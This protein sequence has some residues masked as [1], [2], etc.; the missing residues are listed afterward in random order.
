L[1]TVRGKS[2]TEKDAPLLFRRLRGERI[3]DTLL[4][5]GIEGSGHHAVEA[6]LNS[7]S[8]TNFITK[9]EANRLMARTIEAENSQY[10]TAAKWSG[11]GI[12]RLFGQSEIVVLGK[13]RVHTNAVAN[14]K[15]DFLLRGGKE[16]GITVLDASIPFAGGAHRT[17]LNHFDYYALADFLPTSATKVMFLNRRP[18]AASYSIFRRDIV[19]SL[20]QACRSTGVSLGIFG[21]AVRALKDFES[22]ELDY[23]SLVAS[24]SQITRKIEGFLRIE[25][26][27]LDENVIYNR[28]HKLDEDQQM[29]LDG[30]WGSRTS[31]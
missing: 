3:I 8:V 24:P 10:F 14:P 19:S 9:S 18:E 30:F 6:L 20:K 25:P 23:D 13:K 28:Q 1:G 26:H 29:F 27:S 21:Q 12:A 17:H 15:Y 4:I 7:S 16:T 2:R 5:V 11:G 22:F 31:I